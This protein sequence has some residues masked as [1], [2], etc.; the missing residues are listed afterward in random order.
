MILGLHESLAASEKLLWV[1]GCGNS[2]CLM[3][4]SHTASHKSALFNGALRYNGRVANDQRL[5]GLMEY[6]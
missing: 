1:T 5:S 2:R 3:R 6:S 4:V